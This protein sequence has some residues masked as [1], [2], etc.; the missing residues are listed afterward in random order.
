MKRLLTGLQPSGALHLGNWVGA[1]KPFVELSREYESFLMIVDYHALTTL[2]EPEALR[3]N[4]LGIAKDYIA[5]GADPEK[6]TIFKQSDVPEHT[7]L[8]WIFQ[9]LVTVPFLQQAHAYKD[10]VAKGLE[11]NA[12]LFAYP[13]LMAADILLYDTDIVPVGQDQRQHIEYAREAAAKFNNTY[14]EL[15]RE[16]KEHILDSVATVPGTDG[17]KM[18][19]SYKNTIPLFGTKDEIAKAVMS[20]ITDSKA[21]S[22]E[23][24]YNIHSLFRTRSELSELYKANKGKYQALK[25]ALIEDIEAVVAPMRERRDS[26]SDDDVRRILKEG[27]ERARAIAGSKMNDVRRAIGVTI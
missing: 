12:G 5:A 16:P 8:A 10:K 21:E 25:G 1:L 19:K 13:M 27:S 18:S 6:S 9:C 4:I 20:I 15:F 14:G 23:N 17:Q 26:I 7:E 2:K 3:E 11:A 24:V 22:P